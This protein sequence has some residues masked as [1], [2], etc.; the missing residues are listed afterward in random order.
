MCDGLAGAR[1]VT[2]EAIEAEQLAAQEEEEKKEQ[3]QGKTPKAKEETKEKGKATAT[4]AGAF[5]PRAH[6]PALAPPQPVC[7]VLRLV[8][9]ASV[10]AGHRPVPGAVANV[11]SARVWVFMVDFFDREQPRRTC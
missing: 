5:W 2:A 1:A 7:S 11:S 8:P 4:K 10:G 6:A 9:D 3:D